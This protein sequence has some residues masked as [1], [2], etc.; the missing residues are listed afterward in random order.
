MAIYTD[1]VAQAIIK[2]PDSGQEWKLT[3]PDFPFLTGV[4]LN[5]DHKK[6]TTFTLNFDIPYE[7]GIK[8]MNPPSPFKVGNQVAARIGYASGDPGAWTP[9]ALGFLNAGGDGMSVDANG[10]SGQI[11]VQGLAESY[12]YKV[13]KEAIRSAGWDPI[14]VLSALAEGMGLKA[15]ISNG[16]SAGLKTFNLIGDNRGKATRE[17][18]SDF[19]SSLLDL[20][21]WDAIKKICSEWNFEFWIAA[22]DGDDDQGRNLFIST[23]RELSNGVDK[24]VMRNYAIRGVF[25]EKTHTYPCV[26]SAEG[27]A[28]SSWLVSE[29][30]P[31]AHGVQGAGIDTD[32]GELLEEDV[33]PQDQEHSI[34]GFLSTTDPTSGVDELGPDGIKK[35]ESR[36]E[37]ADYISFPVDSGS[38][39]KFKRQV[40]SYQLDGN[41]VQKGNITVIGIAAERPGNLCKVSGA[42]GLYNDVYMIER[43]THIYSPG[44]WEMTLTVYRYG[45]KDKAGQ[46]LE[47]KGGQ[48]PEK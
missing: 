12:P 23:P 46:K 16:V 41:P 25:D 19:V 3:Y 40:Q 42:G 37:K 48:M 1:P 44:S 14:K 4:T 24:S 6:L 8:L 34:W 2:D 45:T 10:F 30:S 47:T 29:P 27:S 35:D 26:W 43:L 31:A 17:K 22:E 20:S 38:R 7:D 18:T 32:S 21:Y 11:T 5:Y 28:V 36:T 15:I 9:W 13:S 33:S 39:D